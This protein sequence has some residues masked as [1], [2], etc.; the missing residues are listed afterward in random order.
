MLIFLTLLNAL[1]FMILS[2]IHIYWAFGGLWGKELSVP[3]V[4]SGRKLFVPGVRATL[5]VAFCLLIFAAINL[6]IQIWSDSGI[7]HYISNTEFWLSV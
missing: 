5:T 7:I 1:I 6:S 3:T 4:S 2:L